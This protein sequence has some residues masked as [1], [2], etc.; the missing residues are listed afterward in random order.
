MNPKKFREANQVFTKPDGWVDGSCQDLHVYKGPD[1]NGNPVL[2]SEWELNDEE[3]LQV[4]QTRSI[5]LGIVG[6][7]QPPVFLTIESP[8]NAQT[9]TPKEKSIIIN[10]SL[11]FT[12]DQTFLDVQDGGVPKS[13]ILEALSNL[14][15]QIASEVI[16]ELQEEGSNPDEIEEAM[17]MRLKADRIKIAQRINPSKIIQLK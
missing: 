13:L 8:F 2:I 5:Y 3:I 16:K 6:H 1:A 9:E 7:N 4:L 11:Q 12:K 14:T 17:M 15:Q 10:I